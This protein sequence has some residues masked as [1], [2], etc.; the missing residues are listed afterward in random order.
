MKKTVEDLKEK[1][2]SINLNLE[3][4]CITD[5]T[6]LIGADQYYNFIYGHQKINDVHLLKSKLGPMISGP[7]PL[8]K[9][10]SLENT[11]ANIVTV[12]HIHETA[13]QNEPSVDLKN[14]WD[15]ETIGISQQMDLDTNKILKGFENSISFNG[16]RYEVKLPWK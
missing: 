6:I 8:K 16:E 12:L 9:E 7:I 5:V 11:T 3:S 14:L 13:K 2:I 15:L 1:G 10:I 4:G